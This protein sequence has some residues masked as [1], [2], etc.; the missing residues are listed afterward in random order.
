MLT[1]RALRSGPTGTISPKQLLGHVANETINCNVQD[2]W[3]LLT[4]LHTTV[5]KQSEEL[6][7]LALENQE[8]EHVVK[9]QAIEIKQLKESFDNQQTK[10][11]DTLVKQDEKVTF[12]C[13]QVQGQGSMYVHEGNAMSWVNVAKNEDVHNVG[14][15]GIGHGRNLGNQEMQEVQEREKRC[16]NIVVR[17]LIEPE[18]ESVLS[19]NIA[20]TDFLAKKL[21]MQDVTVFGA[22]RVGKKNN[23]VNRAIVC[24]MLDARKQTIILASLGGAVAA[25]QHREDRQGDCERRQVTR[26]DD[27]AVVGHVQ[28]SAAGTAGF[29]VISWISKKQPTVALSSTEAEYKAA[30]F[31][32]CEALWLSRLLGD[33]GA[34][35]EQP[36]ML[37]CDNQSCM[38]IAR[39]PVFHARTKHIEVQYHFVR[40]LILDG[41]VEMEYCPTMDNCADIFTKALESK[42]LERHLH[43]I[44]VGPK[45]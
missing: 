29:G 31:A 12:I 4:S 10:V 37:L 23:A 28:T 25:A 14:T 5:M 15:H 32:S 41:K 20:V 13:E 43:Q 21:G 6:K 30:C 1:E 26:A 19:L 16:M 18:T 17:G 36:T 44:G 38:A 45:Q 33:M 27:G 7:T 9:A 8:L 3:G 34:I 2:V 35:Q 42:T 11:E 22:H 24:T 40:E 39:N